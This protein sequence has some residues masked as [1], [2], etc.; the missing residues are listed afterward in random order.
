MD[1]P[2]YAP[3]LQNCVLALQ[4]MGRLLVSILHP[5]FEEPGSAW[6]RQGYVAVRDYFTER[7]IPQT[8]GAFIHRP[9]STYLNSVI[10]A[11]CRISS[12]A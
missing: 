12:H 1:I 8:Y 10:R 4:P 6:Q 9:L 5:C 11:G 3:A 2:D 7:A